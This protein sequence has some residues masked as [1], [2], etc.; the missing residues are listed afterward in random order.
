MAASGKAYRGAGHWG[1]FMRGGRSDMMAGKI[2]TAGKTKQ[3]I[4]FSYRV[5]HGG[6]SFLTNTHTLYLA[7]GKKKER[8]ETGWMSFIYLVHGCFNL[9]AASMN[10]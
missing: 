6:I 7:L 9:D 1:S 2:T 10:N 5:P 3:H 8:M 4:R